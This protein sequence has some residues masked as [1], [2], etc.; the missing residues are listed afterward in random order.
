M[1][2]TSYISNMYLILYYTAR[3]QK[4]QTKHLMIALKSIDKAISLVDRHRQ[5]R[6]LT[7]TQGNRI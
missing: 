2:K 6:V 3:Q 1:H 4:M 7:G 5:A